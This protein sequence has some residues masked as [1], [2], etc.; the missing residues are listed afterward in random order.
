MA[1][2]SF[3]TI[4]N[5]WIWAF[6]A[7][8]ISVTIAGVAL[9]WQYQS[10]RHELG[11]LLNATFHGRSLSNKDSRTIVVCVED[12]TQNLNNI[13]LTPTFDNPDEFSLHDFSLNFEVDAKDVVII[14][15][16]F[17]TPYK[18]GTSVLYQYNRDV[19]QPSMDT[20]NPFMGFRLKKDYARCEI[21]SKVSFDGAASL[22][23]YRTD[24]WFV[25]KPNN[26]N[27]PFEHW[28]QNCKQRVFELIDDTTFD[29]YYIA[30]NNIPEYQFD[31]VL[32]NN[33]NNLQLDGND[34]NES[35][36]KNDPPIEDLA[37][38]VPFTSEDAA[39][40]EDLDISDYT[41]SN[42]SVSKIT[43]FLNHQVKKSG[44]YAITVDVKDGWKIATKYASF[45]L[46]K[47]AKKVTLQYNDLYPKIANVKLYHQVNPDDYI[48]VT[49][50]EKGSLSISAESET[51]L[52]ILNYANGGEYFR[53]LT[54]NGFYSSFK[55]KVDIE[56][57]SITKSWISVNKIFSSNYFIIFIVGVAIVFLGGLLLSIFSE[58]DFFFYPVI[59]CSL[60]YAILMALLVIWIIFG[61]VKACYNYVYLMY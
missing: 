6:I 53:E 7:F 58:N 61:L 40:S 44:K 18:T 13:Y 45:N 30:R 32:S 26:K 17:V 19:L 23:Q 4:R 1:K 51:P 46:E 36:S 31:V 34:S 25:Y 49:R 60:I 37:S 57:F 2:K 35:Q 24:V 5:H 16:E 59:Y 54:Q 43:F 14:P 39:L 52:L 33:G 10:K 20:K 50:K 42:D 3:E 55:E 38:I 47:G 21:I 56:V 22:F 28:K 15:S 12:S 29:I 11:G 9:F 41:L 27:V 48:S 8:L